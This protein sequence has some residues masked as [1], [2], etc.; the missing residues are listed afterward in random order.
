MSRID[1]R[2]VYWLALLGGLTACSGKVA[3]RYRPRRD[4]VHHYVLTMR[5]G[6]E[7]ARIVSAA[8]RHSQVWTVYYTQFGR[9]T[10]LRGSGSEVGLQVDS[11]QLQSTEDA[12]DLSPMNGQTISAFF[13]GRGQLLR[14]EPDSFQG[15]TP[16]MVLRLQAMAAAA[17]PAFPEARVAAGDQWTMTARAPLEEFDMSGWDFPE[18]QLRATLNAIREAV[19]D[20]IAEVGIDG[21]LPVQDTRVTTSLGTLSARSS[22]N[23]IGQYKF[24]LPRGVMISEELSGTETLVT[25][26]PMVGRDTLLSRLVTQTTIRLQ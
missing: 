12:P 18:L 17:A 13:D 9:F 1:L 10:D 14:T 5:Y 25:D 7:D 26:A 24:S 3:L 16:E 6:R 2:G 15:L 8:P 22:G 20:R 4:G 23:V 19:N 21:S 11:S